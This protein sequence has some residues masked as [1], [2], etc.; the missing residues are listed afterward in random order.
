M[1]ARAGCL[2]LRSRCWG[3]RAE[4]LGFRTGCLGFEGGML[5]VCLKMFRDIC[6]FNIT[7]VARQRAIAARS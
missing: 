2:G 5:G 1:S 3:L 4:C 7:V 6:I